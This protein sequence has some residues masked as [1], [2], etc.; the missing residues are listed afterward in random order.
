M[1]ISIVASEFKYKL[2]RIHQ[3]TGEPDESIHV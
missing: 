3:I 1:L 2:D